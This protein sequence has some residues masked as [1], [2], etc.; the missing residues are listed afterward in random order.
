MR[1]NPQ[2]ES[3]RSLQIQQTVL[4][5]NLAAQPADSPEFLACAQEVQQVAATIITLQQGRNGR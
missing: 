5:K 3:L 4:T 2:P 1:Q